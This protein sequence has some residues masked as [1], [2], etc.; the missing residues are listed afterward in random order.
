MAFVSPV[1]SYYDRWIFSSK[2]RLLRE[3]RLCME[4]TSGFLMMLTLGY[5][6]HDEVVADEER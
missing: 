4:A 6:K 5:L 2:F 3:E 1:H